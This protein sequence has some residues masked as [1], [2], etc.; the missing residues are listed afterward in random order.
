MHLIGYTDLVDLSPTR[1][2]T[3][4]VVKNRTVLPER[5][6]LDVVDET[7][8]T[9]VHVASSF[10]LDSG[11]L[12]NVS[13]VRGGRKRAF[14][15]DFGERRDGWGELCGAKDVGQEGMIIQAPDTMGAGRLECV[16]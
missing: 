7:D 2:D 6:F 15:C 13:R 4:Y 5:T 14:S 12:G 8:G 11:R 9:E 3:R 10:A 16:G 1:F